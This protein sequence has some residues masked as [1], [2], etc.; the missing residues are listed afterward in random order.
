MHPQAHHHGLVPHGL[1]GVQHQVQVPFVGAGAHLPP[2]ASVG[3]ALPKVAPGQ[4][5]LPGGVRLVG[6]VLQ[7]DGHVAGA[8]C[9]RVF[10]GVAPVGEGAFDDHQGEVRLLRGLHPGEVLL[11]QGGVQGIY[12]LFRLHPPEEALPLLHVPGGDVHFLFF[13]KGQGPLVF[14]QHQ[15]LALGLEPSPDEVLPAHHGLALLGVQ[16]GVLEQ[17]AAEDVPQQAHGGL[18]H[19]LA[20]G[21]LPVLLAAQLVGLQHG[22]DVGVA[23]ELVHPVLDGQQVALGHGQVLHPEAPAAEGVHHR[24]GVVGDAPVGAHHPVEAVLLPQQVLHQVLAVGVP[25]VLAVFLV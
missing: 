8:A 15:G 17:A 23:P 22:T 25:H 5:G 21:L 9:L 16:V 19:P 24:G 4:A 1:P 18:L 13:G 20:H 10:L 6:P 2:V 3:E 12:G 7:G 14:H 11:H